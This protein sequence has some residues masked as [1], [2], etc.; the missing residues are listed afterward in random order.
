MRRGIYSLIA[1]ILLAVML[2]SGCL[3]QRQQTIP[4]AVAKSIS[5]QEQKELE[6][7]LPMYASIL[8]AMRETGKPYSFEDAAFV[9]TVLYE[10][11]SRYGA[12]FALVEEIGEKRL[13][14]P[15]KMVQELATEAF[16]TYTDLPELVK[17]IPM[18]YDDA[19]DAYLVRQAVKDTKDSTRVTAMQRDGKDRY[20]VTVQ[21][22]AEG[23]KPD[24]YR[25]TV[26]QNQYRDAINDPEFPLSVYGVEKVA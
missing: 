12:G 16:G 23:K 1:I 14:I 10:L 17:G 11:T 2:C 20:T 7:M 19:W 13:R 9:W 15:R 18:E 26:G 4:V 8:R 25:F 24:T 6:A 5:K 3:E 22:T 21:W